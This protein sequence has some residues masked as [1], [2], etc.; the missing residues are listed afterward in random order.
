VHLEM[1][2]RERARDFMA[3]IGVGVSKDFKLQFGVHRR[4]EKRSPNPDT[5]RSP[6][7]LMRWRDLTGKIFTYDD[8][9]ACFLV[10]IS[11]RLILERDL[12]R[13]VC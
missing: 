4:S 11:A 7:I 3:E 8:S 2:G 9:L 13:Y 5:L 10:S 6:Q 1:R 12:E